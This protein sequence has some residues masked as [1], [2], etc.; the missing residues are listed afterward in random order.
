MASLLSAAQLLLG[1]D[2]ANDPEVK[3][4]ADKMVSYCGQNG[5]KAAKINKILRV[6][7]EEVVP[8]RD[9]LGEEGFVEVTQAIREKIVSVG[10]VTGFLPSIE[11]GGGQ[12]KG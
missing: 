5:E 12:K 10:G 3:I 1:K 6:F 2:D 9:K 7:M 4:F 8:E 11:G